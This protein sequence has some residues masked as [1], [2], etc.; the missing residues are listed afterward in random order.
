M[1]IITKSLLDEFTAEQ[2]LHRL[3]EDKRFEHFAA[4]IT[5]KR[6]HGN[7]FST[8]D[9]VAGSGGDSAIDAFAA[10]VNGTL[11]ADMDEFEDI[12]SASGHLDVT[13]VVFG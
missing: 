12:A 1:N 9:V 5:V 7:T 8:S 2:E 11:V 10:I 6:Q 3:P 13:F 4:F